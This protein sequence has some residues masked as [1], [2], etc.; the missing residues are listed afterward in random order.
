MFPL[1]LLSLYHCDGELWARGWGLPPALLRHSPWTSRPLSPTPGRVTALGGCALAPRPRAWGQSLPLVLEP[2]SAE[3]TCLPAESQP[4]C[5]ILSPSSFPHLVRAAAPAPRRLSH[6]QAQPALPQ[7]TPC[8]PAA[9]PP[10]LGSLATA[11]APSLPC[12]AS[13]RPRPA[14][15]APPVSPGA[16]LWERAGRV[17]AGRARGRAAPLPGDGTVLLYR[18]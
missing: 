8:F 6:G 2:A 13:A 18:C 4:R 14:P 16:V 10:A 7:H 3:G 11:E 17:P 1:F 9:C 12:A 15:R 5:S